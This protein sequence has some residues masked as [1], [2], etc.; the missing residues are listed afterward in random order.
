MQI[1]LGYGLT[2]ISQRPKIFMNI[3]ANNEHTHCS[4]TGIAKFLLRD[5]RKVLGNFDSFK[6]IH[7]STFLF[8]P[9]KYYINNGKQKLLKMYKSRMDKVIKRCFTVCNLKLKI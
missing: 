2:D 5:G 3:M 7:T 9:N 1:F 8:Y 4:R 6:N